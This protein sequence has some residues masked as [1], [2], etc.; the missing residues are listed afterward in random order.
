MAALSTGHFSGWAAPQWFWCWLIL[1]GVFI[2]D[3]TLTLGRRLCRGEKVYQAHRSHAY[4]HAARRYGGHLPVTLGA[5]LLN[6]CWL[7]P[8]ALWVVLGGLDGLA[9]LMLAYIPLLGLAWKLRA[10]VAD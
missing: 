1:L 4:Q 7:L 3:A 6:L 10:G 9:G 2:V 5:A 8:I